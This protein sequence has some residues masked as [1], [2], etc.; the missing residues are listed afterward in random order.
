[1]TAGHGRT[2]LK[3]PGRRRYLPRVAGTLGIVVAPEGDGYVVALAGEID[4]ATCEELGAAIE[5]LIEPDQTI[6]VDLSEVS[7]MDSSGLRVFLRARA[8]LNDK[9]GTLVLRK[10]TEQVRRLFVAVGLDSLL[11]E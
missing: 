2:L 6:V 4:L 3:S 11:G 8:L 9:G 7:F 1:M 10:P 5:P